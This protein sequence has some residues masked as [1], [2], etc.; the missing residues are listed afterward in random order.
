MRTSELRAS[1]IPDSARV[2][3]SGVVLAPERLI[4]F[5]LRSLGE[6]EELTLS[7]TALGELR[8]KL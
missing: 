6:I 8:E 3:I 5:D 7:Q 2:V 4:G 1:G